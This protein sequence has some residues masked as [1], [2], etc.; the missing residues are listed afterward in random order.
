MAI[1]TFTRFRQ[2]LGGAL[3]RSGSGKELVERGFTLDVELAAEY[4]VS[5]V[6]PTLAREQFVDGSIGTT[7]RDAQRR[8]HRQDR[9][10]GS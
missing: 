10:C 1:A 5:R 2:D 3:F 4:A 7:S 6:A 9:Q 8:G